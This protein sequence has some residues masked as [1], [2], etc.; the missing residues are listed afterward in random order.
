MDYKEEKE[1]S[2]MA[3]IL[4]SMLIVYLVASL[5]NLFISH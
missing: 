2:L 4:F 1:H 3:K 5:I